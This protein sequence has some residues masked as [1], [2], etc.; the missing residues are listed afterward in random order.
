M[1][2]QTRF[3]E[4]QHRGRKK[5]SLVIGMRNKQTDALVAQLRETRARHAD[6]IEPAHHSKDWDGEDGEPLHVECS[7]C[8]LKERKGKRRGTGEVDK[9]KERGD[10][11]TWPG[12]NL[13]GEI[14]KIPK[15]MPSCS[16]KVLKL[17][18]RLTSSGV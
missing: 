3:C 4:R 12:G 14:A 9:G 7:V 10:R 8:L 13:S 18:G 16:L 17:P 5:H 6:G 1:I 2:P 15:V 11:D